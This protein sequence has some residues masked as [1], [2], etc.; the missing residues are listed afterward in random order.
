MRDDA[1]LRRALPLGRGLGRVRTQFVKIL[2]I[3]R[4]VTETPSAV[5]HRV[6][7]GEGRRVE[8]STFC[9]RKLVQSFCGRMPFLS[10]TSAKDIHWISSIFNDQQTPEGRN[11]TP[12]YVCCQ[13]SS[14]M[15]QLTIIH[16]NTRILKHSEWNDVISCIIRKVWQT[17]N[18]R[19]T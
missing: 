8:E 5:N 1:V 13:H 17:T 11:A 6:D 3:L 12:F 16:Y 15:W 18:I 9:D 14:I 4:A 19:M 2:K 10:P 7:G